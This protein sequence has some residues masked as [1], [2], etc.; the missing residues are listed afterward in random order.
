ICGLPAA[1][2]GDSLVCVGPPDSIVKGSSSVLISSTPAARMGD[3]TSHG[4]S[5]VVGAPTV[6]IGG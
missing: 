5:I 4:G 3:T 1:K 6:Q 2:M